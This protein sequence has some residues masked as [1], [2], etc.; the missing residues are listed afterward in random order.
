ML[1]HGLI[2][3]HNFAL[4]VVHFIHIGEY[5]LGGTLAKCSHNI[6][7]LGM[8]DAGSCSLSA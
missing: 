1:F 5:D 7:I 6:W 8:S 2:D 3:R 4:G